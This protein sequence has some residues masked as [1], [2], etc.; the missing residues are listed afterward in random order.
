ME[1]LIP[2]ELILG[3]S[4]TGL[5]FNLIDYPVDGQLIEW[6]KICIL[7]TAKHVYDR[8]E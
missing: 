4:S 7:N 8:I 6:T 1:N 5:S 3:L 2:T